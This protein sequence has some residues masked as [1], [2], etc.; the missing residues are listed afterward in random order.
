MAPMI[1][2]IWSAADCDDSD[3]A[4]PF[5]VRNT[6]LARSWADCEGNAEDAVQELFESWADDGWWEGYF[7]D[8]DTMGGVLVEIHEPPSIA[9]RYEVD[10]ARPIK[11]RARKV[12]R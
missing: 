7:G 5:V 12:R 10:L 2:V 11:A 8:C 3:F 9:G 6:Y 1:D 4:K